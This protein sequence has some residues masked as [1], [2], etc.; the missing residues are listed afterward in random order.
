MYVI[1]FAVGVGR[2]DIQPKRKEMKKSRDR[3]D[4]NVRFDRKNV[5]RTHTHSYRD[6]LLVTRVYSYHYSRDPSLLS[7]LPFIPRHTRYRCAPLVRTPG[8]LQSR[9]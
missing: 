4:N 6:F 1:F 8:D 7:T 9:G 3:G 2:A 5:R